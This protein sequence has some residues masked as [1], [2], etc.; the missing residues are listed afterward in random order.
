MTTGY[1]T[2]ED[3]RRALQKSSLPG[4]LSQDKQLAVDAIVSQS[5][6][7][8]RTYKRHWY[9]PTGADILDEATEI[10]IPTAPRTRD[11]EHDISSHG[12]MV[13][14]AS[15]RD[16]SR[17]RKNSDALLESGPRYERRRHDRRDS[18][19]EIRIAIGEPEALEPPV[20]ETVPAYTRIRLDRKDV[21]AINELHVING[22]GGY[23]DWVAEDDYDGGAGLTHRGED[24]WGRVNN[25][26]I[27]ELYLNVHA[28]D[29]EIASLSKAVYIDWD[30]GREGISRTA[31]RAVALFAGAEFTEEIGTQIPDNAKLYNVETKAEEMRN[32]AEKLLEPDAEVP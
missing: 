5:R 19:Q 26:G 29:D 4:D 25:D 3:V 28:M 15:E 7:L 18:K 1:C 22:D 14:G 8:E 17:R 12:A 32:R 21:D 20:D 27:S 9:A 31:R 13:H 6:W 23:D 24:Y 10:D 16:R 11:D 30:Y 2:L